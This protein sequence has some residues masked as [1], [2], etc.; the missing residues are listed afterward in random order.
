LSPVIGA[1]KKFRATVL[2]GFVFFFDLKWA[3]VTGLKW[4]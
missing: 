4:V 2:T 3:P 1:W